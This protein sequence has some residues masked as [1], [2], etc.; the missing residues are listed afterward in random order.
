MT[1]LAAAAA[2]VLAGGLGGCSKEKTILPKGE[3]CRLNLSGVALRPET[4][5]ETEPLSGGLELGVHVVDLTSGEAL[6]NA[7]LTN[8]KHVTDASG[9]ISNT[10]PDPIVL[11]TGYLYDVYA[12]SPYDASVTAATSS[13]VPVGHGMDVLWAKSAGEKP[14][15]ATHNVALT[16][17]R[18]AAQVAFQVVADGASHPDITGA[19]IQVTGFY[20]NGTLDL[21][22]GKVT[23]G[24]VDNTIVWTQTGTPVCFLPGEKPME[25]NVTVT[26]PAG[27]NAGVYTGVKKDIFQPG[28]SV[29]ITVTV[30][31][32][33]SSLGLEAGVVPWV[34]ETGNVDVNN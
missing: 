5:A 8:I 15:A 28:K 4:K 12:Y 9:A 26:I 11:T 2:V 20:G 30:V 17:E 3:P 7:A 14:N 19:T 23:P 25:F 33:N 32:R 16:F 10:N 21:A 31:D 34:N 27:P 22:T 6:S 18:K 24:N 13:A 29:L 1:L